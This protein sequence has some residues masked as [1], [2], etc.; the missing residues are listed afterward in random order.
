MVIFFHMNCH[1]VNIFILILADHLV[2]M[3]KGN[4]YS[5][6]QLDDG[7]KL[8]RKKDE[9]MIKKVSPFVFYS[10]FYVLRAYFRSLCEF[11]L[12]ELYSSGCC[13]NLCTKFHLTG[14]DTRKG[15]ISAHA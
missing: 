1:L 6:T 10:L 7:L 2:E 5:Q 8:S 4:Q 3:F 9:I 12:Y 13:M 14:Y 11:L 15:M